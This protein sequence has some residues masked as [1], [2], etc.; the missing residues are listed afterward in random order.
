MIFP[1]TGVRS[2]PLRLGAWLLL[3]CSAATSAQS[4]PPD[5]GASKTLQIVRIDEV[6]EI[7][8][9]LDEE[10]WS[11]A[12][13]VED[14]HQTEPVEYAPPSQRTE[15]RVFFND[16][17]LYI[18]ARMWDTD[19]E[20]ITAHVLR[21]GEGMP[22]EDRFAVILDP[23]LDRRNGYRFQV[24][25]NGVRW[26]ALYQDTS[27]LESNWDGIWR[28]AATR[29]ADGWTAEMEI[30]FKTL[31][32]N[33]NSAEWGI[34]FER[35]IQ[36]EGETLAWVSRNRQLNPGVAGTAIGFGGLKQGRGL[37]RRLLQ[38]HAFVESRIDAQYRF[39]RYRSG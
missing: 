2:V 36:R 35:T 5:P 37:D 7:D 22:D 12:A 4:L 30:P 32:F 24:N 10:F 6:P 20:H 1:R 14:L 16:D 38:A 27:S 17:A 25:P 33:P 15:I 11:R 3:V 18:G 9:V 8:G 13:L 39:L 19:A 34:N 21:Q 26:E 31:S 23:Y 29:D 28:T